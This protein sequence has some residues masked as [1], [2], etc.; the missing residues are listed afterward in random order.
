MLDIVWLFDHFML[1]FFDVAKCKSIHFDLYCIYMCICVCMSVCMSLYRCVYMSVCACIYACKCICIYASMCTHTHTH[2]HK[3]THTHTHTHT[4]MQILSC[5]KIIFLL[6]VNI[7][8]RCAYVKFTYDHMP[9][10]VYMN[11]LNV[12]RNKGK[13][14]QKRKKLVEYSSHLTAHFAHSR[15]LSNN[16]WKRIKPL[17]K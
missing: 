6:Y 7:S 1:V 15:A 14:E 9:E 13:Y 5:M 16:E 17:K 12:T 4:H 11:I 2:T 3:H 8:F 10:F